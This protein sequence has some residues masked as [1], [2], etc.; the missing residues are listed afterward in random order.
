[1]HGGKVAT[2]ISVLLSTFLIE[3]KT[4]ITSTVLLVQD[5]QF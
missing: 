3:S 2:A 4:V 1:M 5:L